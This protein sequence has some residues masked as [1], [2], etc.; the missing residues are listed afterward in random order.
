MPPRLRIQIAAGELE[1]PITERAG[2]TMA[3]TPREVVHRDLGR[4]YAVVA[5][6]LARLTLTEAEASVVVAALTGSIHTPQTYRYVWI[7]V[8]DHLRFATEDREADAAARVTLSADELDARQSARDVGDRILGPGPGSD[9]AA[10]GL[11]ARGA[12][13]LVAKLRALS[14]GASMALLDAAERYFTAE[15]GHVARLHRVGL[16]RP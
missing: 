5:D 1:T 9:T 11:G 4:Y 12:A 14:P 13:V 3:Q 10:A 15:G 2:Q 6:E 16:V 8:E 7:D